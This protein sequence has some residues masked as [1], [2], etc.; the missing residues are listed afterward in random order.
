MPLALLITEEVL[1]T[2]EVPVSKSKK[3]I[4]AWSRREF[5]S[6]SLLAL[7]STVPI[8][9]TGCGDSSNPMAPTGTGDVTGVVSANHGHVAVLTAAQL[10][11]EAEISLDITGSSGHAHTVTITV[12]ELDQIANG[13]RATK[14]SSF[15][16]AHSH[17]VTFN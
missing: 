7:L 10:M 16:A 8:T 12:A 1:F 4:T 13:A 17:A 9:I 3:M 15:D 5:T 11:G 2:E 6:T 14:I